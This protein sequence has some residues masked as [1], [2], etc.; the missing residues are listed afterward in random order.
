[1]SHKGWIVVLVV[2]LLPGCSWLWGSYGAN[3][4]SRKEFELYVENVFRLQNRLTSDLMM[5][6]ETS[7][8]KISESTLLAEQHM[9]QQCA[10][11]NEYVALDVDGQSSGFFLRRRVENT[12]GDCERAAHDLELLIKAP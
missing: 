5:L 3:G 2:T 6:Q 4:Q 11:L 8:F 9:R 7:D 1:V 12:A 10:P